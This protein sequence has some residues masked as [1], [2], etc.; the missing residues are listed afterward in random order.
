M[1]QLRRSRYDSV[2]SATAAFAEELTQRLF[3]VR[4][5]LA[6][7]VPRIQTVAMENVS[8][9]S[10]SGDSHLQTDAAEFIAQLG[11]VERVSDSRSRKDII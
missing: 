4:T 5:L 2:Q 11:L 7:L 8:A 3:A 6:L 1:P 9:G 10:Y